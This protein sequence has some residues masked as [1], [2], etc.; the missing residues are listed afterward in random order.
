MIPLMFHPIY[1]SV[2][3]KIRLAALFVVGALAVNVFA[4]EDKNVVCSQ[5]LWLHNRMMTLKQ[6]WLMIGL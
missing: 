4:Q 1:Q 3:K 2:M 5:T 6:E